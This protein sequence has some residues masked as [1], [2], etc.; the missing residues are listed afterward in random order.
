MG[1]AFFREMKPLHQLLFTFFAVVS[2][3]MIFQLL[4]VLAAIPV[5]GLQKVTGILT[6]PDLE[7]PETITILKLF[8]VF[9]SFGLFIVPSFFIARFFFRG[10]IPNYLCLDRPVSWNAVI[11]VF[12]LVF[13]I[14]PFI[15]FTVGMNQSMQLPEWLN[16]FE[17][18]I[19]NAEDQATKL[20]EAFM[21]TGTAG[22]LLFNLFM[23]AVLP[24]LGEELLFRGVFQKILTNLTRNPHWGIWLSAAIFSAVHMQFYGFIPRMLLGGLF[25]YLLFWSGSLWL[26]V[27]GHFINNAGAVVAFWLIGKGRIDPGIENFGAGTENWYIALIS[28]LLGWYILRKIKKSSAGAFLSVEAGEETVPSP[29]EGSD[30]T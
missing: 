27:I 30:P 13:L 8:Q 5:V 15:N 16:G 12:F 14:N 2:F 3:F 9:Q 18:W 26:P 17:D 21:K 7:N 25:G 19:K 28:L 23:I 24:A 6:S 4:A 1:S 10:S 22:G 29:A 20:T 11:W